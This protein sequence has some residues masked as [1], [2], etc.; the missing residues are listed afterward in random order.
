LSVWEG[1]EK[2]KRKKNSFTSETFQALQQSTK[3]ITDASIYLLEH[4]NFKYVLSGKLQ[5]DPLEGRF[6]WYRQLCGANYSVSLR[7][8]LE[9]EK[10]IKLRSLIKFTGKLIWKCHSLIYSK[11]F[12]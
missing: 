5:S 1:F 7:Q 12:F 8:V 4:R 6:G 9:A 3:S 10:T 2:S 11:K